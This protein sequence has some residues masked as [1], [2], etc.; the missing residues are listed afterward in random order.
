MFDMKR[1]I[2][3]LEEKIK[4]LQERVNRL[5]YIPYYVPYY[6]PYPTPMYSYCTVPSF[7]IPTYASSNCL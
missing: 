5:Y 1:K 4:E 6:I 7:T 2:D 3:E